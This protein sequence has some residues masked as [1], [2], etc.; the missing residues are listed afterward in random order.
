MTFTIVHRVCDRTPT[1]DT[2]PHRGRDFNRVAR[3]CCKEVRQRQ[4][5]R[6]GTLPRGCGPNWTACPKL[7]QRALNKNRSYCL[8]PN[9]EDALIALDFARRTDRLAW[10]VGKLD[11]GSAVGR[12]HFAHN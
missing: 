7:G 5:V 11:G 4:V 2:I 3:P 1:Q 10:I 9:C 6:D 8:L 12:D